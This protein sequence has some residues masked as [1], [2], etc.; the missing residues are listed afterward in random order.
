MING[1][2]LA[3]DQGNYC[4]SPLQTPANQVYT[5][6]HRQTRSAFLISR[7]AKMPFFHIDYLEH[8]F[9]YTSIQEIRS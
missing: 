3:A 7:V 6:E 8:L 5:T 2:C 9:Y 4:Q 1:A